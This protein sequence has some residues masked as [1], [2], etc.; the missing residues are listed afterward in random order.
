MVKHDVHDSELP[1]KPFQSLP[2]DLV[3]VVEPLTNLFERFKAD[4]IVGTCKLDPL[5]LQHEVPEVHSD[6]VSRQLLDVSGVSRKLLT[7][8]SFDRQFDPSQHRH[9]SLTVTRFFTKPDK[10][11]VR[12]SINVVHVSDLQR[13][14]GQVVL[15]DAY[16]VGPRSISLAGRSQ[17]GSCIQPLGQPTSVMSP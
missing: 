13:L 15:V 7:E 1:Q 6:R 4:V 14:L 17:R 5:P 3:R 8:E 11:L 10:H 12:L 9:G 16:G 2:I